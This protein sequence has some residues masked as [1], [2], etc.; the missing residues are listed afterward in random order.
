MKERKILFLCYGNL[1]RSP[2]AAGFFNA[3]RGGNPV[4]AESAGVGAVEGTS[5][6]LLAQLEMKRRGID[7][8]GHHARNIASVDLEAYEEIIALDREVA[9][10]LEKVAPMHPRMRVWNITDPYGGSAG[11]YRDAAEIVKT[12]VEDY[13]RSLT[14]G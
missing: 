11:G 14:S 9:S 1:C 13:L 10:L 5:A 2:M 4:A 7:I 12:Y 6:A 3:L 8:S